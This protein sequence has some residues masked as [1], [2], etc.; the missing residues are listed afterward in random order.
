M[1]TNIG[2]LSNGILWTLNKL[3]TINLNFA[4]IIESTVWISIRIRT[5]SSVVV[6]DDVSP[7]VRTYDVDGIR[8]SGSGVICVMK[9]QHSVLFVWCI[10]YVHRKSKE[11]LHIQIACI[12]ENKLQLIN[13]I[14]VRI[15]LNSKQ[16]HYKGK[17]DAVRYTMQSQVIRKLH[18]HIFWQWGCY[19]CLTSARGY[20]KALYS[21]LFQKTLFLLAY[22][23]FIHRC[24]K[25]LVVHLH[26]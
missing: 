22:Q 23:I 8:Y 11:I 24:S 16:M 15:D 21:I 17:I 6:V 20:I 7:V 9:T 1:C 12:Y 10:W 5:M 25:E 13:G 19:F 4:E 14:I 26:S 18:D 2:I 3:S